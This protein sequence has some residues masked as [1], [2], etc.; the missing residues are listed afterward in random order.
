MPE[1]WWREQNALEI[2]KTELSLWA[3]KF[4]EEMK[5]LRLGKV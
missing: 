3:K 1:Q 5:P 2:Q 4:T